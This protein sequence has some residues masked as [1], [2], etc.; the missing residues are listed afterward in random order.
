MS[1][2]RHAMVLAVL[3]ILA[4][5]G[6]SAHSGLSV[7]LQKVK[8]SVVAVGT[9]QRTRSPAFQFRG[10]GFVI[11]DGRHLAT[12]AHVL[13]ALVDAERMEQLAIAVPQEEGGARILAVTR[14]RVDS[15]H[16]L[17]VLRLEGA[18]LTPLVMAADEFV[19]E[20]SEVGF[21][22]FPIG[23]ALGLTPVTHRGIVSALTPIGIPQGNARQLKADLVRRLAAGAFL[24]YQLDAT[25]YP[26]SSGSPLFDPETAQVVG[27]VNMVF[28]KGTKETSLSDPSGITYAIPARY[29]RALMDGL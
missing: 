28:V 5:A 4:Q 8:P 22:G 10:T 19:A 2:V 18:A 25:A 16:D 12:N 9:Y 11:G 7:A 3:L 24:V 14:V 21:T 1:V 23:S 29:L 13:P 20:G 15:A 27:I 6:A 17:A 26:G